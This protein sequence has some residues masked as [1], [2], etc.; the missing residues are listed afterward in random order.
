M[1]AGVGRNRVPQPRRPAPQPLLSSPLLVLSA[2]GAPT[3]TPHS[4]RP[5]Q[6]GAGLVALHPCGEERIAPSKELLRR[7]TSQYLEQRNLPKPITI[8]YHASHYLTFPEG[9]ASLMASRAR[10]EGTLSEASGRAVH[11]AEVSGGSC[12]RLLQTTISFCA[13]HEDATYRRCSPV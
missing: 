11:R 13:S 9:R 12:T 7:G 1:K 6:P 2:P 10:G 8:L 4:V 3:L 5:P